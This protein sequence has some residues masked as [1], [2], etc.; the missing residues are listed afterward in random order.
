MNHT[1]NQAHMSNPIN[2]RVKNK[3]S[4]VKPYLSQKHDKQ[5]M[6]TRI[7]EFTIPNYTKFKKMLYL[8][9]PTSVIYNSQTIYLL[10]AGNT[11]CKRKLVIFYTQ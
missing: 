5:I 7:H 11:Y 9:F 2:V 8:L 3:N 4:G 6:L 1:S 10:I